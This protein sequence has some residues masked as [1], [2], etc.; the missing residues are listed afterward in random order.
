MIARANKKA[1]AILQIN[2]DENHVDRPH[3]SSREPSTR[4]RGNLDE[5]LQ[6]IDLSWVT[7]SER[8]K[9]FTRQK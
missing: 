5:L 9:C 4:H 1:L 6:D 7:K 3:K 8:F 2:N